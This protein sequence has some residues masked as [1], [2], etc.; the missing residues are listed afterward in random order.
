MSVRLP[1]CLAAML[2]SSEFCWVLSV[3]PYEEVP[4][5]LL[6]LLRFDP[7]V[8]PAFTIIQAFASLAICHVIRYL[9]NGCSFWTTHLIFE[10]QLT[11]VV[12]AA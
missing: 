10:I 12:A 6:V 7:G 2:L 3:Q 4:L 5:A 1:C 11:M 8:S 9:P